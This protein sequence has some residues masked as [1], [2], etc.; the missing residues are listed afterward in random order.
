MSNAVACDVRRTMNLPWE[1]KLKHIYREG[2]KIADTLANYA[3]KWPLG[4][5]CFLQ[6]PD[7]ILRCAGWHV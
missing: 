3:F 7:E 4:F 1:V 6:P 5:Y 2:N